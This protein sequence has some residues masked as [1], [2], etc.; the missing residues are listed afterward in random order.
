[1]LEEDA[2]AVVPSCAAETR[3]ASGMRRT[4][5]K[6][7]LSETLRWDDAD[8]DGTDENQPLPRAQRDGLSKLASHGSM[9]DRL[10]EI[11]MF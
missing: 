9:A 8:G 4:S 3:E 2:A 1:M 7:A 10:D 6:R 5:S 11:A